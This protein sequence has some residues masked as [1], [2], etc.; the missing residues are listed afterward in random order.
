MGEIDDPH[1]GNSGNESFDS[2]ILN[3]I[4]TPS[5]RTA[6]AQRAMEAALTAASGTLAPEKN[7]GWRCLKTREAE[8]KRNKLVLSWL[9]AREI[10]LFDRNLPGAGSQEN[11]VDFRPLGRLVGPNG[12]AIHTDQLHIAIHER[13]SRSRS[14]RQVVLVEF[15]PPNEPAIR[16]PNQNSRAQTRV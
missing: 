8:G 10:D 2:R 12:I 1:L 4:P 5:T 13:P 9:H 14:Q 16:R 6:S 7:A 3:H 15:R 11:S